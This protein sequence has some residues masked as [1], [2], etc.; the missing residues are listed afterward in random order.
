[1]ILVSSTSITPFIVGKCFDECCGCRTLPIVEFRVSLVKEKP[2]GK[3]GLDWG[4]G[5]PNGLD[6][7]NIS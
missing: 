3:M 1:M 2:C 5:C 4:F 7:C 6:K